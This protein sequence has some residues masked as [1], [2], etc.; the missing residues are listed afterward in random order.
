MSS[1]SVSQLDYGTVLA[2]LVGLMIT[3]CLYELRML[4]PWPPITVMVSSAQQAAAWIVS[5]LRPDAFG[6]YITMNPVASGTTGSARDD[7]IERLC[8]L[9]V[10]VDPV[11]PGKV[12]ATDGEM[13]AAIAKGLEIA[14]A[15]GQRGW[16]AQPRVVLSG[17]GCH[18]FYRLPDLPNDEPSRQLLK[19]TLRALAVEF[20]TPAVKVDPSVFNPSRI[21]RVPGTVN[22]KGEHTAE[23]PHRIATLWMEAV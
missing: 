4:G 12:C 22:R 2:G 11:R 19:A 10:D 21:V 9:L 1:N 8:W 14:Q 5:N 3:G 7:S 18:L 6:V 13:Q 20:D 23:R 15:L 17:S 16:P